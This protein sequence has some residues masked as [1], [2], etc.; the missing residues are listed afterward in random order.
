MGDIIQRFLDKGDLGHLALLL[1]VGVL[2]TVGKFL[3][4]DRNQEREDRDKER[5]ESAAREDRLVATLEKSTEAQMAIAKPMSEI[6][7]T[8][9]LAIQIIT[10][11][12]NFINKADS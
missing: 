6:K 8:L 1:C 5:T 10:N 11:N 4:R 7:N 3:I 12:P 9:D 2:L